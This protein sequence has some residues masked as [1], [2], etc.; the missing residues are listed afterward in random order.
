MTW[1]EAVQRRNCV[2]TR[3]CSVSASNMWSHQRLIQP[4][5]KYWLFCHRVLWE[6]SPGYQSLHTWSPNSLG[7]TWVS[8]LTWNSQ[9][10]ELKF[11]QITTLLL[12]ALWWNVWLDFSCVSAAAVHI[13]WVIYRPLW[14]YPCCKWGICVRVLASPCGNISLKLFASFWGLLLKVS[15]LSKRG[16]AAAHF[17]W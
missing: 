7:L 17:Y 10:F 13:T 8:D 5:S 12:F 3:S 1:W 14:A 6:V 15:E 16:L 2:A 4:D 11:S 9:M